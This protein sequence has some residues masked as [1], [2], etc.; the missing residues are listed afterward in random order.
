[1][2]LFHHEVVVLVLSVIVIVS[3]SLAAHHFIDG[4]FVRMHL[5]AA[6]NHNISGNIILMYVIQSYNRFV[7]T[8]TRELSVAAKREDRREAEE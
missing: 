7:A 4:S 6:N 1:M 8:H 2:C 5:L 3:E